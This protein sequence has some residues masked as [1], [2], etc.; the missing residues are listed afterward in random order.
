MAPTK[1]PGETYPEQGGNYMSLHFDPDY[2]MTFLY[3]GNYRKTDSW[4]SWVTSYLPLSVLHWICTRWNR[5]RCMQIGHRTL[6]EQ[7]NFQCVDCA[8]PHLSRR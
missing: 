2:K 5:F 1:I 6:N 8:R 3:T 7:S 4:L